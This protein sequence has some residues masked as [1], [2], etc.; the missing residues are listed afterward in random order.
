MA[1]TKKTKKIVKKTKS[2]APVRTKSTQKPAIKAKAITSKATPVATPAWR[3]I[4]ETK[5]FARVYVGFALLVLLG[6]TLLWS[7]LGAHIQAGN[8][9][10][11]INSYLFEHAATFHGATLPGQ[12]TF[13]FKWPLFLAIKLAGFSTAAFTVATVATV[14]ATV[15]LFVWVLYRIER[16]PLVFGTICIAL[17][18]ALLLVPTQPYPGGLLPVNM[19]MLTTRNLE[20]I[21]YIVGLVLFIR[22]PRIRSLQFWSAVVVMGLLIAS[23]KLFLAVGVGAA[24]VSLFVYAI[25]RRTDL[26]SFSANW[27]LGELVAAAGAMSIVWGISASGLAHIAG[28]SAT[29]PYSVVQNSHGIVLGAIYAVLGVLTNLG[30]NPAFDAQTLRAIPHQAMLHLGGWGGVGFVA[31]LGT[32]IIGLFASVRLLCSSLRHN[33]RALVE[34]D[35][36]SKLSIMMVWTTLV[37]VAVFVLSNH[38]FAADARY[39][40]VGLFAVF[41]CLATAAR[42]LQW[43]AVKFVVLGLVITIALGLG[44]MATIGTYRDEKVA[45]RAVNER[46]TLVAKVLAQHKV[47]VLI[48][49]Y[50][51][52]IPSRLVSNNALHVMPLATCSQARQVLSSQAWQPD[53]GKYGFA[54][55]ISFD[56]KLTDYPKCSLQGIIAAYGRPNASS[57]VAGTLA[58]PKELLLFYDHGLQQ[59]SPKVASAPAKPLATILPIGLGD[60]TN[61]SCVVPSVMN[62]VAHQDDDLLFM[63]PDILHDIKADHCVRSIYVT[64]GDAGSGS[65]YWLN[66]EQAVEAAYAKMLGV[67]NDIWVR[68]IVRLTEGQYVTVANPRGNTRV[69]LIF[70]NLPDGNLKGEGFPSSN[71]A[72]LVRLES[73]RIKGMRTVDG[74]SSYTSDQLIDGLTDLMHVYQPAAIRTQSNYSGGP[75]PDHSDHQAVGRYTKKAYEQYET[76]Q[77]AGQVT[78][79]IKYYIGY[80]IHGMAENVGDGELA[81][82]TAIFAAYGQYD[83]AICVEIHPCKFASV[84][85]AYLARQYEYS[86]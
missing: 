85:R 58:Q 77:L 56:Q 1:T 82:K 73:G 18:C 19:A 14:L 46:D 67:G 60:L 20:Y 15:F 11:L 29:G 35:A 36:P 2:R 22:A 4:F 34:T 31:N 52:V 55:L 39:L 30:A 23:D 32:V 59:A 37:A 51:R 8:A 72:S 12:H 84:F 70:M 44:V 78:I 75:F 66:R 26:V 3:R 81:E 21:L 45:L 64:A 28:Q 65:F 41:I 54:Y 13:L 76:Q 38:Y 27:L 7:L 40:A 57:L 86:E 17:A 68:R 42:K 79:P 53:I 47:H 83:D 71:F 69:S 48:G 50:W 62:I 43:P 49:D 63:N 16:R 5:G 33:K 25:A 74:Q 61:T 6:T 24:I 80:P 10:Q 9:D